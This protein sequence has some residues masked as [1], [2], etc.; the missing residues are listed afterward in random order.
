MGDNDDDT[1]I[2]KWVKDQECPQCNRVGYMRFHR[3]V[4][5]GGE[6]KAFPHPGWP[7]LQCHRCL[8]VL[9]STGQQLQ[10]EPVSDPT[11]LWRKPKLPES[12]QGRTGDPLIDFLEAK[13]E[14]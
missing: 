7:A 9:T 5:V 11:T 1:I 10:G 12:M 14:L 6:V 8:C 13:G 4:Q 3:R 2:M